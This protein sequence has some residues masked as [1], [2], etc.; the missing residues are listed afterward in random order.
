MPPG[1]TTGARDAATIL[2]F[3]AGACCCCEHTRVGAHRGPAVPTLSSAPRPSLFQSHTSLQSQSKGGRGTRVSSAPARPSP[4]PS[5]GPSSGPS[6]AQLRTQQGPSPAPSPGP[7]PAPSSGPSQ[8]PS[9]GPS[10]GPSS[11]PSPAPSPGPSPGPSLGPSPAPSPGPRLGP[12]PGPSSGPSLAPNS[13]PNPAEGPA[14]DT[15]QD[16]AQLRTQHSSAWPRSWTSHKAGSACGLDPVALGE[17]HIGGEARR[18]PEPCSCG[19]HGER[20]RPRQR[21]KQLPAGSPTW[22]SIPGPWGHA[23]GGRQTLTHRAPQGPQTVDI[24]SSDQ[25]VRNLA[26]LYLSYPQGRPRKPANTGTEASSARAGGEPVPPGSKSLLPWDT[27]GL[28]VATD[29]S[30]SELAHTFPGHV[31]FP[32]LSLVTFPPK[33]NVRKERA[34]KL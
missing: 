2:V 30:A 4:T 17:A 7:S 25:H 10:P 19:R 24:K 11:G 29:P 3:A 9:S 12:S 27:A 20:R 23:L 14:Q 21:E 26:R 18:G 1:E 5:P 15:A 32:T 22:D 13:G 31:F 8:G 6:P 34:H 33:N 16:T 28:A